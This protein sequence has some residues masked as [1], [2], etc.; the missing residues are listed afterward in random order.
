MFLKLRKSNCELGFLKRKNPLMAL[1]SWFTH[2]HFSPGDQWCVAMK[3]LQHSD[4]LRIMAML[5]KSWGLPSKIPHPF[6]LRLLVDLKFKMLYLQELTFA[7]IS[8]CSKRIFY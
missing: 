7:A 1:K 4:F 8:H 6:H 2:D 5:L 3:C